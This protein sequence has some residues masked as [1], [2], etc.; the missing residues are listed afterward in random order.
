MTAAENRIA[1]SA[2]ARRRFGGV[3]VMLSMSGFWM[4]SV[5]NGAP[6]NFS[7]NDLLLLGGLAAAVLSAQAMICFLLRKNRFANWATAAFSAVNIACCYLLFWSPFVSLSATF[8]IIALLVVAAVAFALYSFLEESTAARRWTMVAAGALLLHQAVVFAI[9]ER[10]SPAAPEKERPPPGMTSHS[11]IR[12][13]EFNKFPNVY[14]LSFDAL[15]PRSLAERYLLIDELP[16]QDYLEEADFHVFR[17]SFVDAVFTEKSLASFL[18]LGT[19]RFPKSEDANYHA[20]AGAF[21][22]QFP[23]PLVEIFQANGY[24]ANSYFKS[25]SFG[26]KG[27]HMDEHHINIPFSACGFLR[28]APRH[29]SFWGYCHMLSLLL[30]NNIF[31]AVDVF[32]KPESEWLSEQFARA[33][34]SQRRSFFIAYI[35]SPGHVFA[36]YVGR[37]EEF[38]LYRE[39]FNI[40][41]HQAADYIRLL[42]ESILENDP[43]ALIFI[44]GDHGARLTNETTWQDQKDEKAQA[45]FIRDNYAVL[46]AVYPKDACPEW[47]A[48][49]AF[50]TPAKVGRM[51]VR[52]LSGEDPFLRPPSYPLDYDYQGYTGDT[53]LR[54]EDYLYE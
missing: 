8:Q 30:F 9:G 28:G 43:D 36:G 13:V 10:L 4:L 21:T 5:I 51:I 38:N 12:L 3:F 34:N 7:H 32:K 11:D 35:W 39:L 46:S 6:N 23:S 1:E 47:H 54:Y 42:T 49:E 22:G 37:P 48:P 29:F 27:P 26:N 15:I 53:P 33:A 16:Y 25:A 41:K 52:C 17:N 20:Y 19:E 18:G 2:A 14:A 40:G 45:F 24:T 44:F 50:I 31:G